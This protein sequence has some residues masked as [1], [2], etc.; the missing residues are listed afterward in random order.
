[1]AILSS[2]KLLK[3][4]LAINITSL[5]VSHYL[6]IKVDLKECLFLKLLETTVTAKF[7][8]R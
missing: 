1:M 6:L 5:L 3:G 7:S 4:I 2:I 8:L